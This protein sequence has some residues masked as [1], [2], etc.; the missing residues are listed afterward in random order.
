MPP[1]RR[2]TPRTSRASCT[3]T[4]PRRR[5]RSC[6]SSSSTSSSARACRTSSRSTWPRAARSSRC[7]TPSRSSSTTRIPALAIVELMRLLVDEHEL[8]WKAGVGDHAARVLL[9]EPHAAARG[10]RDLAGRVLRAAAAAAPA[11]HLPDQPRAARRGFRALP[12]GPR[13][14]QAPVADRGELRPPGADGQPRRRRQ[15]HGQRRGASC[16]PS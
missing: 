8:E 13:A 15:P 7:P 5:A 14:A 12:P 4:T 3:P 1:R 9:H 16:T 11:D 10:A 6:V 2:S